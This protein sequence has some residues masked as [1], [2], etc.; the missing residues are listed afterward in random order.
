[1]TQRPQKSSRRKP[2]EPAQVHIDRVGSEGDG[3]ARLPD[4]T[5]LYLPL[6]LPGETVTARPLQSRGDRS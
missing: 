3:I 4:G 5:S 2:P 6:T 1:M